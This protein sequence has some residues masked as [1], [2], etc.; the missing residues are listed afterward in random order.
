MKLF[1]FDLET[2]GLNS[3]F[4]AVH[5]LSAII[6]IDGEVKERIDLKI[7]P[8]KDAWID[9][10]ALEVGG[11]T[12]EQINEYPEEKEAYKFLIGTLGKYCSKFDKTDKYF[13][14]GYNNASFDNQFLRAIWDRNNDKYFGSYFWSNSLDVMVLASHK[15]IKERPA[16]ENFKLSTV[17]KQMGIEVDEAQLHNSQ[18]DIEIT[19]KIF[20]KTLDKTKTILE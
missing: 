8:F 4:H 18:F 1:Y 12:L 17:A 2:T 19:R 3:S 5:Q 16:M 7:K 13:L 14:V 9:D 15:L 20:L 10:K 6:E 11:V